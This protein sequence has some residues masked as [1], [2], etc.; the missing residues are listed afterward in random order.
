SSEGSTTD[1]FNQE[2]ESQSYDESSSN[3]NGSKVNDDQKRFLSYDGNYR[4]S[5]SSIINPFGSNN[6]LTT[7][8]LDYDRYPQGL[9]GS[10]AVS[11]GSNG[12]G[13]DP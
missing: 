4:D 6:N 11:T 9:T 3:S 5:S 7:Q 10:R 13:S 8:P 12:T 1:P 2:Y